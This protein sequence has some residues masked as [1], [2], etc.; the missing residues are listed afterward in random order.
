MHTQTVEYEADGLHMLGHLVLD[1][2]PSG[3]RRPGVLVFPEAFGLSAHAKQR[4]ERLAALGYVAL[5]GDLHGDQYLTKDLDEA[6]GLIAP[7]RENPAGFSRGWCVVGVAG[8]SGGR[9]RPH[10]GD[11][12]LFRRNDGVGAGPLRRQGRRDGRLP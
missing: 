2:A 5:A 9:P 10:R 3:G 11:R 12:V 7:L 8:A 6:L 1:Q 4:A